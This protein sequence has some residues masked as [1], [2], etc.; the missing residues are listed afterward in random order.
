MENAGPTDPEKFPFVVMGNKLDKE[1]ER[2]VNKEEAAQWCKDN[3]E[4]PYFETSALEN[5]AVD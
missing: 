4:L 2:Q 1:S 5:T 3:G